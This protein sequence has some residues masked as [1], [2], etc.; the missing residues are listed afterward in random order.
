MVWD[1]T[2]PDTLA[3][4]Y[5]CQATSTV[6]KVSSAA[7]KKACKDAMLGQA[8]CFVPVAIETI[9]AIGPKTLSFTKELG[10]RI[11]MGTGDGRAY[12][13]L[14][15]HLSVAVQRG[16]AAATLGTCLD[17]SPLH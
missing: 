7:E 10:R 16:S 12:S 4:S 13:H 15:Q 17:T 2:C 5:R 8:Y 14:L 9:G 11:M 6:G 1:T 3:P